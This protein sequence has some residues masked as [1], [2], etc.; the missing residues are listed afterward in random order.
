[1][2]PKAT[3][4]SPTSGRIFSRSNPKS[5]AVAPRASRAS[6]TAN[7]AVVKVAIAPPIILNRRK[8]TPYCF[9]S[10]R[11]CIMANNNDETTTGRVPQRTH[12]R[13]VG[14]ERA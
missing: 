2:P 11:M 10:T 9:V 3:S 1:M 8:S 14:H 7:A 4:P 12:R 6:A 13:S 5:A